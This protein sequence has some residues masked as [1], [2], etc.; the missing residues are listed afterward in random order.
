MTMHR[1]ITLALLSVALSGVSYAGTVSSAALQATGVGSSDRLIC[2]VSN[3]STKPVPIATVRVVNDANTS[4]DTTGGFP[5]NN[6]DGND[7]RPRRGLLH[8]HD[9]RNRPGRG[10][11]HRDVQR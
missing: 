8:G 4:Q 5:F 3:V 1:P 9:R 7:R 10:A 11:L 2:Q 6:C